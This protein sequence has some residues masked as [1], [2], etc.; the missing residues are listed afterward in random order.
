[1][2]GAKGKGHKVEQRKIGLQ[3]YIGHVCEGAYLR[4]QNKCIEK[5]TFFV[6]KSKQQKLPTGERAEVALGEIFKAGD[7]EVWVVGTRR[8]RLKSTLVTWY[9]F[10]LQLQRT[11]PNYFCSPRFSFLFR[12]WFAVTLK[13]FFCEK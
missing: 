12:L 1:M 5:G 4:F 10:M 3:F 11:T 6:G 13:L 9:M 8:G 2:K 7:K